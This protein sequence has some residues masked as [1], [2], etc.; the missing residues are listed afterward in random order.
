MHAP[1]LLPVTL[2]ETFRA[3]P[4]LLQNWNMLEYVNLTSRNPSGNLPEASGL[5]VNRFCQVL[6][7]YE[8]IQCH[9]WNYVLNHFFYG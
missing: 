4:E 9:P 2:P 6:D 1:I 5:A 7:M 3:L 8:R